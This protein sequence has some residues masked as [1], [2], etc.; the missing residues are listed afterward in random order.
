[1]S[2]TYIALRPTCGHMV[3]CAVDNPAHKAETAGDVMRW[4]KAGYRIDRVDS[5][6]IRAGRPHG[7]KFCPADCP[8][9]PKPKRRR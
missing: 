1:M 3:A 2:D 7:L 8:E 6:D 9:R 5:A 4:I